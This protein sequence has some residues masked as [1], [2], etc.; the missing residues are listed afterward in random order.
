MVM[1]ISDFQKLSPFQ[2]LDI[3]GNSSIS[4]EEWVLAFENSKSRE[5]QAWMSEILK[6]IR[7]MEGGFR[8]LQRV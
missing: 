1:Q 5:F 8:P 4:L 6:Q 2:S 3:D 7:D